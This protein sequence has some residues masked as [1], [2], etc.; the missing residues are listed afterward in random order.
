M[1]KHG[2]FKSLVVAIL[3]MATMSFAQY[4]SPGYGPNPGG[5][6]AATFPI[7]AT[8]GSTTVNLTGVPASKSTSLGVTDAGGN[9]QFN[10]F[11]GPFTSTSINAYN[12]TD[13]AEVTIDLPNAWIKSKYLVA[14]KYAESKIQ[15]SGGNPEI[16]LTT[17]GGGT[18]V[19]QLEIDP[20]DDQIVKLNLTDGS[21]YSSQLLFNSFSSSMYNTINGDSEGAGFNATTIGGDSASISYAYDA[22]NNSAWT[23]LANGIQIDTNGVKPTCDATTVKRHYYTPGGAGVADAY[24]MCMKSAADTYAWV[25]IAVN[26]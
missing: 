20:L 6:G 9:A 23:V 18:T 13:L 4:Q 22:T 19:G 11:V 24:E 12:A 1:R 16:F 15:N 17:Y 25:V 10:A 21:T 14:G 26:P 3:F 2:L 7:T 8:D 5:S